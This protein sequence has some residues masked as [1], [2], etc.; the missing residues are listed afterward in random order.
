MGKRGSDNASTTHVKARWV[1]KSLGGAP[2]Y[3]TLHTVVPLA[4]TAPLCPPPPVPPH[5]TILPLPPTFTPTAPGTSSRA[6]RTRWRTSCL[7]PT[8]GRSWSASGTTSRWG[9][10]RRRGSGDGL[11]PGASACD[12]TTRTTHTQNTRQRTNRTRP[13]PPQVLFWDVRSGAC[14]VMRIEAAHGTSHDIHCVDWNRLD[15]HMIATGAGSRGC[16]GLVQLLRVD[17]V[18]LLLGRATYSPPTHPPPTHPPTHP[19]T[20]LHTHTPPGAADGSLRIWDRR[21]L[22]GSAATR[23]RRPSRS[24]SSTARPS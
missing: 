7:R 1:V 4:H 13:L 6:T 20:T 21:K 3:Q 14:P 16:R 10:A 23:G 8:A 22:S 19:P 11:T 24:S 17:G 12:T 2:L 9:G 5:L 18:V 15:T